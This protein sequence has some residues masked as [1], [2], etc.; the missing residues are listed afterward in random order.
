MRH[1][2]FT[3]LGMSVNRGFG[4]EYKN[5]SVKLSEK[6]AEKKRLPLCHSCVKVM[7][8]L[9]SSV[10][11]SIRGSMTVANNEE[12]MIK[13]LSESIKTNSVRD[14]Y[15]NIHKCKFWYTPTASIDAGKIEAVCKHS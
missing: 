6:I 15:T 1:G 5:F 13:S 14:R 8:S 7:F 10:I 2:S 3:T 9:I 12:I 11:L 4:G